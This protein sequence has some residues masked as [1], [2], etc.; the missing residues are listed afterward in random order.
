MER[1]TQAWLGEVADHLA[2]LTASAADAHLQELRRIRPDLA[3]EVATRSIRLLASRAQL[4]VTRGQPDGPDHPAAT[5]TLSHAPVPDKPETEDLP[6]SE[7]RANVGVARLR[8]EEVVHDAG[9]DARGVARS[10][11]LP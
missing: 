3:D 10:C 9:G 5:G 8:V 6:F 2:G 4:T 1:D 7:A 11:C